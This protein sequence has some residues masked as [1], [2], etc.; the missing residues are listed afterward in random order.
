[1][2][3]IMIMIIMIMII[4]LVIIIIKALCQ[5][6]THLTTRQSSTRASN[7]TMFCVCKQKKKIKFEI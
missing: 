3:M 4:I 6:A 7:S 1:M 5:E 2:I